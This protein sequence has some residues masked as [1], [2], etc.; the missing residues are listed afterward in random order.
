MIFVVNLLRVLV[1]MYVVVKVIRRKEFYH[2]AMGEDLTMDLFFKDVYQI[3][4]SRSKGLCNNYLEGGGG[5][6]INRG[7]LNLNQSA[8]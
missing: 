5:S 7:G 3:I 2:F 1:Q 8:G 4:L 6:K